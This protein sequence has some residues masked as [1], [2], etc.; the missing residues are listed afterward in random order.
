ME[1]MSPH[2]GAGRYLGQE[3]QLEA[4]HSAS[5][6]SVL[7]LHARIWRT[8]CVTCILDAQLLRLMIDHSVH[9]AVVATS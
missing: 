2:Y 4:I 8:H 5:P 1:A 3:R 6:R 7:M 9:V